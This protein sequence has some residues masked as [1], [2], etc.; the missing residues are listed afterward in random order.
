MEA[1]LLDAKKKREGGAG[2]T[3]EEAAA[4]K[5]KEEHGSMPEGGVRL[6]RG[7]LHAGGKE[8]AR[9]ARSSSADQERRAGHRSRSPRT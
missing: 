9:E 4:K 1:M 2:N 5:R 7:S 8:G 6:G 3:E